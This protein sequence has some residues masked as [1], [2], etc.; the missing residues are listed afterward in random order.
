MQMN[1]MCARREFKS[2]QQR[3]DHMTMV[4]K[5]YLDSGEIINKEALPYIQERK[6]NP[7][8]AMMDIDSNIDGNMAG[9]WIFN[10]DLKN[11]KKLAYVYSKLSILKSVEYS[12]PMPF[13]FRSDYTNVKEPMFHML[14]SDST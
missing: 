14:M 4:I 12:D 7:F 2:A 8:A 1:M 11:F 3:F 9:V 13:F 5:S 6:G 10:K